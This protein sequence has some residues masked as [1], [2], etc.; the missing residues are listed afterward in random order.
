MR[1]A[2]VGCGVVAIGLLALVAGCSLL[3]GLSLFGAGPG[4]T[5]PSATAQ[6]DVPAAALANYQAAA[7]LCP[8]LSWTVLAGI[9]KVE[10]DHGRSQLPGVHSGQNAAGA[11][12]P[13]QFLPV[14]WA[15]YHLPGLDDVYDLRDAA[16]A[17][18]RFL[19]ASGAG[20]AAGLRQAI[21]AYN[22]AWTYVDEVLGWASR[23]AADVATI[24]VGGL[25]RPGDP[26]AAACSPVVTQPYGPTMFAAEPSLFGFLH[27]HSGIDLACPEGVPVHSLS[28][29]LAHVTMGWA[30]GYGDNVVVE[31][32]TRLP[33]DQAAQRYFIRYAHLET[34]TVA[35]GAVVH[36]GDLVGLEGSTGNSTGPHLHLELDRGAAAAS[37]SIDPSSLL[38]VG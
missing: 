5:A 36:S 38:E 6:A 31:V 20:V 8:G 1:K 29:G 28:G 37:S 27:F 22:H 12:G 11:E 18:S 13:M 15:A 14:T 24:P 34:V 3:L 33:G 7:R 16:F 17:A 21:W 30:G 2:L 32:E 25:G 26:F 9:G 23:Y 10:S 35:D 19:C 4:V